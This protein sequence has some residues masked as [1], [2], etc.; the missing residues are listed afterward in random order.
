[1]TSASS[2]FQIPLIP[3]WFCNTKP[4][5]TFLLRES[6]PPIT[7]PCEFLAAFSLFRSGSISSAHVE[8]AIFASPCSS[9][10]SVRLGVIPCVERHLQ[11]YKDVEP[12]LSIEEVDGL[13][14]V[15]KFSEEMESMLRRKVVAVEVSDYQ[16]FHSCIHKSELT[17]PSM[18]FLLNVFIHNSELTS[19][20]MPFLLNVFIHNSELTS[21][22]VPFLLNVFIHNSELTS[23]SV[24][25]LLNVFIHNFELTAP[26]MPFLLNVYIHNPELTSPSMP[27]LLNVFIYNSELTSPSMPFLL[28][29]FIHNSELTSLSIPFL[30]NVFIYN[31]ELTSP[32]MPFL[33]NVY[34]H[35]SKLTSPSM[36]FLLNVFI[37]NSELTSP[38]MPFLLNVFIYNSEL[39]SPSI[40]FLLN[41]FIYKSELTSLSIPFLL[42]VFIYNSELTSPS[43][44]F[45]LNVYIHNS[46]LTSPSMPFLLNVF[47]HNTELTSPSIPFL[48]N[49]F[50][51]NSELTSPSMP[52]L[53]NVFIHNSELTSPSMPFL[54]NV[55]IHNCA[56]L[57]R[58]LSNLAL[59]LV[60]AAEEAD[61]RHEFNS[62]LEI[63]RCLRERKAVHHLAVLSEHGPEPMQCD[64]T[65]T[66]AER[67]EH[68]RRNG[69]CFYCGDSTHAISDCPKRTKRF[70]RSATI[71][72][73]QSK[74]LLSVTLIC[75]LSSYSVMAFVDSGAALNL[76]DLEYARR[77]G[78]FLEPLQ[79]PI[80]LRGID[81][82]PLAKNKP[83]YWTQ[84][85]MC[86]APAHQE[87][88]R[89]LVLHNLHDVVVLGLPWLQV[90]NP[91][92][93]WKSMSV[94]GWGCQGVHGDIPFLSIS[95]ST[96]SEVP[97]FL[98]DYRDVFDEPKSSALPPH[99]DCD[100]AINLIP[101]SKFPKGR[102]FNLSVPEHAAM[103]SYIKES[104][105][106]GHIRPSSSPLGA[107]F[108]FVAKKDGSLRPCIDY[109]LLNK[110][111]VK[112]QYP[113]LLLSDLFA[114]I[115]GASWFTKIDLRGAYNLVRIKQGDEWKT[116][117]N[118][119]E[120]HFEYLVMP[121]GLSNA[122]SVF[123]SFMHDI[124]R[125][126][127]DKFL[128]V[129]LDD[130]LVFS[131]DWE[132][133]VKQVEVDASE[134]GAGAVLS[135]R[136]SDGSVMKPCAYFSRK[137]SP[138]ERNYDVASGYRRIIS[139]FISLQ[140]EYYN[141][142]RINEKDDKDNY[143]ELGNE[144][145]LEHNEHFN[146]L[147]V[148]TTLSNIQL[149]TNV[150]NKDPD[151]LNGVYMSEALNPVF[152][153][154]FQRDPTLTWQYFGSST[155]FFPPLSRYIQAATSPKDIVIVVDISG[156]MKGLRMTIAKHTINTLLDTLGENDFVNIIAGYAIDVIGDSSISYFPPYCSFCA[157]F[158][159]YN[160]YVHY[161]EPCFKGI[162][163]QADRDNR[164]HFKQLVDELQ[165]KGVGT[166][167][168]ALIEAFKILKEFREAGQGGLC[169]QAIMLITDGAVEDYEQVFEKYNWPDK[170][171]R[172]FTYLIGREVT[173]AQNVKWIACSNKG[174]YTQIS[175]LAD[176]QENVMEYLHVLSRP[177]VINH[178]H[179]II[180]TEA[181]MDS[182]L[183]ASQA[184]SLLLMTTV[185]MPVFSKK[186]ETRAE[187][188]LLGVVGSDVPLRELLKLAPRYKLGVHGYAFLNTNN[189]YILSHPDLRPLYKEGKKLKP[190]PNYNSVDLSEVE[191]EDR[192]E[193]LRTAMINGE[194]GTLSMDVK[195]TVDKGKRV[196]FLT[197]DYFYT[198]I[199]ETPFSL[200]VV[201]TRGHGEYILIGNTSMEEGLHDLL[202]PDLT[203][204][205]EWIYCI[206]DIDPDH[207]KLNQLEA[208]TRF[209]TGEEPDLEC[210]E[211]LVKE[212]LFDA[213]VTAPMEAYWTQL[214]LNMSREYDGIEIAFLGTRAGLIRKKP[215][216]GP[217]ADVK[218]VSCTT[219]AQLHEGVESATWK[220]LRYD[221]KESIFT[222]D[223]FPLWY[224]RAAEHPPGSF[225]YHVPKEDSPDKILNLR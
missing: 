136:S 127:L 29:V 80:P 19:S 151:I 68:R 28:N 71:G 118:T 97:E 59:R 147:M 36:P 137:F 225:V 109:R 98:S 167:N 175:T 160:D 182:A 115:K 163:V 2:P 106:K 200:G 206:T 197:S 145:I 17:S 217:R 219:R 139:P 191:W 108:F 73:V 126:Y 224:R 203:V 183:F 3:A 176:V 88:I 81:A 189:G 143:V 22:S 54:L 93:D 8:L 150:Y 222:M 25:F 74:F 161:I 42:N 49:V 57:R 193:I 100:C 140:F 156:S 4:F 208:V 215:I 6:S 92:L 223:H 121:F 201:L 171:V 31:S 18:P 55:F 56:Y 44:P 35:N 24:P 39:T 50:I 162:L 198:D 202:H 30:L 16:T 207:R 67:Q 157:P 64:R 181:Y 45:L 179:D 61:L 214:A 110:I 86:M 78:F 111:T 37:H 184:Q 1:M 14:L 26:S 99:R 9:S 130:I 105:E 43:M 114:R 85:T 46:K 101:G 185:A 218:Q 142:V 220:F 138:A 159:Q 188:I 129:Y 15:R 152:V 120:G 21:L 187:G 96:P 47:I 66:R 154:N 134:I 213:V 89:F 40:P 117:F 144:F 165:A 173:F 158:L 87:D 221:E 83:Q 125:E 211:E 48:L 82:T 62:S 58:K 20:S 65:L 32:S 51:H 132:S 53:L 180:W 146:N 168:K 91:V 70:A 90:H 190:K 199:S 119:P 135:Q 204:A 153:V 79:Y 38:S 155:G 164:E 177:M 123:Q 11:K 212:V 133:H 170:K 41:V 209:L 102:L 196:L 192:D 210:D 63:D 166:V 124:F 194:T 95:S 13:E 131:D 186:N 149:P 169:N 148:N 174:Y 72:T 75:S 216:C 10:T 116:A 172:L 104:L 33:L 76:M 178:D 52:F 103:R 34:I 113:L 107:G 77:C 7:F 122:P 23:L 94:S 141:S 69:L 60:E 112:F 84:L 128:I 27:F 5:M 12:T 195:V 205:N